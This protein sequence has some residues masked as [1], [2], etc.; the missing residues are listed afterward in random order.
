[1]FRYVAVR[2]GQGIISLLLI[3]V[4]LFALVRLAGDPVA[5]LLP[6]DAPKEQYESV[7]KS[8][9][10][11]DPLY[12]QYASYMT[13]L[14]R[15]DL[16]SSIT[17]RQPVTT[18]IV[19]RIPRTLE[20][21]SIA[22][23]LTLLTAIPFGVYSAVRPRGIGDWSVRLFAILGQSVPTFLLAIIF[24]N[25]FPSVLPSAGHESLENLLLP[26]ATLAAALAA[27]L[28]RLTRSAMLEVM[29]SEYVKMARLKGVPEWKVIW[30][31]ALRNASITILTFTGILMVIMLT[32]S[33]VVETVFAWPGL[34]LLLI[35]SATARDFPVVQGIVLMISALYITVNL[36]VDILYAYINPQVRYT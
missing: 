9:H 30:V 4:I 36:A 33:V 7:R 6:I 3:T 15:G 1:M 34:G 23:A 19:E 14:V 2:I 32:G 11:D 17:S 27:G 31:H 13:A 35:N 5:L 29:T 21:G 20:L 18:L 12:V 28:T 24:V 22:L 8:L 26:A 25:F 10:L 16:G